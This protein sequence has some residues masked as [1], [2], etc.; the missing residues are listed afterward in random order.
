M[1]EKQVIRLCR[2]GRKEYFESLISRYETPLY[3]YCFHL[4]GNSEDAT[5]LFQDTWL[6]AFEKLGSYDSTYA[7]K[8]WLFAITTNAFKDRYRKKV[9]RSKFMISFSDEAKKEAAIGKVHTDSPSAQELLENAE[10]RQLLKQEVSR[11]KWN[12][13]MVI[14]LHYFEDTP[15]SEI[16]EILKIPLGTVK[17]RLN[18]ARKNLRERM[19]TVR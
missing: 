14:V 17:S 1:D 9:R 16:G 18:Q 11:L 12:H 8:S 15:L 7:F 5:D 4:C 2:N 19:D 3:R 6:R 10:I 13:R